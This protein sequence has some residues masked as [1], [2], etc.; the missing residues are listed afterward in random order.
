MTDL[1]HG[2]VCAELDAILASARCGAPAVNHAL[3]GKSNAVG[4]SVSG[5]A[6]RPDIVA[7]ASVQS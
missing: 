5:A 1:D 2:A 6:V 3:P 7:D 4:R